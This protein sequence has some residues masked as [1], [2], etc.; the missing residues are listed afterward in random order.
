MD[1]VRAHAGVDEASLGV[2]PVFG[3]GGAVCRRRD[4]CGSAT[5]WRDSLI[6][7]VVIVSV[8]AVAVR[9]DRASS[10]FARS[11]TAALRRQ[12]YVMQENSVED[13]TSSAAQDAELEDLDSLDD[14]DFDLDEVENKIAPLALAVRGGR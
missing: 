9:A 4:L 10:M 13:A 11:T 12:E 1:V 8:D 6:L 3:D 7:V 14:V 5:G 2:V